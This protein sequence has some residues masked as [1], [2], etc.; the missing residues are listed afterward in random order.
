VVLKH[1]KQRI[2]MKALRA[3]YPYYVGRK[4]VLNPSRTLKVIDKFTTKTAT[5]VSCAPSN[6]IKEA[7]NNAAKATTSMRLMPHFQRKE[8]L[9]QVANELKERKD[10]FVNVLCIEAGKPIKDGRVEIERATDTFTI[11]AEESVRIVGEY[12]P[13]DMSKRNQGYTALTSRFPVGVVSMIVPFNFPVNLAAHKIAPAIAAGCP[14]VLKPSERTPIS[15]VLLGEILAKTSLPDDAF[16]ILPCL[17]EDAP[18]FSTEDKI[19]L[20]SFTGSVPVGWQIKM[21]SGKKR[22]LLELGGNAAC[23]IDRDAPIERAVE[24][25][26]F[27]AF[28]YSG[29]SCI[30]VQ[31]IYIH[32]DLYSTMVSKLVEGAKKLKVGDPKDETTFIGPMISEADAKRLESWVADAV[33]KGG[34]LLT[35]G[36]RNGVLFGTHSSNK[37]YHF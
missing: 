31:R 19:A 29:Q 33:A 14:F 21:N 37:P 23:V 35:G 25:L 26:L 5:E 10:E 27:G 2:V 28:Y 17:P 18:L 13:L 3:L 36:K 7:I 15:A 24:R 34:R 22:V 8:I 30:S 16:A 12:L 32:E 6:V 9:M 1:S 4:A 20:V 11:A